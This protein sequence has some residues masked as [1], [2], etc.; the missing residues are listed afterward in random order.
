MLPLKLDVH[1]YHSSVHCSSSD[2]YVFLIYMVRSVLVLF[3]RSTRRYP[4]KLTLT[5]QLFVYLNV[6]LLV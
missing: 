3:P 5:E 2:H 4:L 6:V 1:Y